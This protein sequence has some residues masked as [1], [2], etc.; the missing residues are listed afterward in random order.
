[1][2]EENDNSTEV[3]EISNRDSILY[4]KEIEMLEEQQLR[5]KSSQEQI[6]DDLKDTD[7]YLLQTTLLLLIAIVFNLMYTA[8]KTD[9]LMF[10]VTF[11]LALF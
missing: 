4:E 8:M 2:Y 3:V 11:L 7:S 6:L 9:E 10:G 5:A 1:M